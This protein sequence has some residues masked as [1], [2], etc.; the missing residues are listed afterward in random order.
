MCNAASF[1]LTKDAVF[2]SKTSNSHE[3][4][5][6]EYG[7][8]GGSKSE[9]A[10]F[11]KPA[12]L[13]VEIVPTNGGYST[14]TCQWQYIVDQ[15][16]LPEWVDGTEEARARAC[17]EY[18]KAYHCCTQ[19]GKELVGGFQV[20]QKSGDDSTQTAGD[21]STQTAGLGTVQITRWYD[22]GWKVATR[23]V[24]EAEAGKTYRVEKGIW[25]LLNN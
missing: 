19:E 1:V 25:T 5:I 14:P 12:I 3:E 17:L 23:T 22:D 2:F 20:L 4:I 15:D 21:D 8:P 10:C 6:R 18:W 13:R 9:V 11:R 16:I 7:L 24:T